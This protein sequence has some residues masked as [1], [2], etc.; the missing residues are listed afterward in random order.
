MSH[1]K[2]TRKWI[3]PGGP[4]TA[5]PGMFGQLGGQTLSKNPNAPFENN[6]LYYYNMNKSNLSKLTK[7]Q[8]IELLIAKQ[9]P[10]PKPRTKKMVPIPFPRKSVKQMVKDY[11][12][13]IIKPPVQFRDGPQ[14]LPRNNIIPAPIQFADKPK[15]APRVKKMAPVPTQRT[16]ITEVAR[17]FKGYTKSYEVGIKNETDPLIQMSSTRLAIAHFMK[18]LLTQ[19]KGIKFI[20]TLTIYFEQQKGNQTVS[21]IGYFNSKPKTITNANDFQ[22]SLDVNVEQIMND[23]HKWISEGSAWII[24]SINGHYINIIK[25]EPLT[26]SSY[27]QLPTELQHHKKGIINL[28]NKDNECFRWCHIRHLNPRNDNPQRIKKI[29]KSFVEKLNYQGI[30]F[31]V[32]IKQYNKIETQNS[33]NI[34]VFGYEKKQPYPI[35]VSKEKFDDVLN[36]L[37]I[38]EDENKHYCLIKD[39][40][41]FM[42]SKNKT[43][44][45]KH[46]CMHCLQCFSK[47]EILSKHKEICM[48]INGKQAIKMPPIGSKIEFTNYNKQMQAPFVIY[49]DSEAIT[50]PIHGCNQSNQQSFTE[51]YQKHTDCGYGYKVVCCYDDKYSKPIKYYRGGKAV[52]KFMQAMLD[53]V[54]YCRQT[55]KYKFNK[56][57]VMSPEDED[58]FQK[59]TSCHICGKK[60]KKTDKRV[61]D[62]CHINGEFRG[63]AHNQCNR[64]FTITNKIPVIFHNL[65]GYDSHFIMQEIGKIIETNTYVDRQG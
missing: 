35:Y 33:I 30:E 44:H 25:Y 56:P 53:E 38:S 65:K 39:F 58:K 54:K 3:R 51:A 50:E 21:R 1:N 64:D 9:K 2:V 57:L 43:Q 27:I 52:Y 16:Q 15:A 17:A 34:N 37:L 41:R 4:Q 47:E 55:I 22:E 20:E 46:F 28:K 5:N 23:I 29:D 59:A 6:M 7:N 49:A 11:E 45:K 31:P 24:K 13:T 8:L 10:V 40:N 48:E 61:R 18:Q 32:S 62:H 42:F 60:Y 36:L 19:M 14:P 63:S 12:N 26:G